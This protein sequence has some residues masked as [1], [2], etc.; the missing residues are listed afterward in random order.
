VENIIQHT[1]SATLPSTYQN[2]LKLVEF[3]E[4]LT[5]TKVQLF[6]RHSVYIVNSHMP[7]SG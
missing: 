3:D 6:L 1:I 5:E 7:T 4:V 2:L